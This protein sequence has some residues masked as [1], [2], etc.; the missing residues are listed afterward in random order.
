MKFNSA[1]MSK[2]IKAII[3]LLAK[4]TLF[5]KN[6]L[7]LINTIPQFADFSILELSTA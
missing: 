2:N 5:T 7:L 3:R 6:F 1:E 4:L